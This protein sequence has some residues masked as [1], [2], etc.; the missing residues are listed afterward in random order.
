MANNMKFQI[1]K[2]SPEDLFGSNGHN[3]AANAIQETL[4]QFPEI[5]LIGLE[6]ELGAG[7]ST[8]LQLLKS[9]LDSKNFNFIEFDV[10][11]YHHSST[12]S[13][14]IK[15]L[16][17]KLKNL[18]SSHSNK[19]DE[20]KDLALGNKFTYKKEVKSNLP[21]ISF[22][23]VICLLLTARTMQPA[24]QAITD[25]ISALIS[26]EPSTENPIF[27]SKQLIDIMLGFSPLALAL[28]L[29]FFRFLG[30]KLNFN[31]LSKLPNIGS[32]LKRNSVDTISETL[33]INKEVSSVELEA[34][35]SKF[36]TIIPEN[37]VV[38]L[39]IDN[40]DRVS[41][42]KVKEI[43]SDLE[44]LT[45]ICSK[46]FRIIV[47]YSEN[48]IAS[49][50]SN[51]TK[52]KENDS[53][54][55]SKSGQEFISKR[56]PVVFRAPPI[57]SAGWREPFAKYWE[58]TLPK[59]AGMSDVSDLIDVW[60]STL[61][62]EQ[63][64]PRF[65]KKHINDIASIILSNQ[66]TNP[67][68][69]CCSAYLLACKL[70]KI[71]VNE[72]LSEP[73]PKAREHKCSPKVEATKII[74][75]KVVG[76]QE[77]P[78]EIMAIHYQTTTE[79]A[80]CELLGEP[81][82]RA[83]KNHNGEEISELAKMYG[84]TIEFNKAMLSPNTEPYDLV[85]LAHS[86]ILHHQDTNVE[87][88]IDQ[89]KAWLPEINHALKEH[90]NN[91]NLDHYNL[92]TISAFKALQDHDLPIN[93][94][95]IKQEIKLVENEIVRNNQEM[96][97]DPSQAT[98]ILYHYTQLTNSTPSFVSNPSNAYFINTLWPNRKK[99]E[100]WGI[101]HHKQNYSEI[102]ECIELIA[103]TDSYST[104]FSYFEYLAKTSVINQERLKDF[105]TETPIATMSQ[106]FSVE[107]NLSWYALPFTT[108]WYQSNQITT[109]FDQCDIKLQKDEEQ[110]TTRIWLSVLIAYYIENGTT[111][112]YIRLKSGSRIKPSD[113][114]NQKFEELDNLDEEVLFRLLS[115]T[116]SFELILDT[117]KNDTLF[118]LLKNT[119][120]RLWKEG[121]VKAL[122]I[123]R[124]YSSD[125]PVLASVLEDK[126][127]HLNKLENWLPKCTLPVSDWSEE[128]IN[129]ILITENKNFIEFVWKEISSINDIAVLTR[130]LSSEDIPESQFIINQFSGGKNKLSNSKFIAD[131]LLNI[132]NSQTL[133]E[134]NSSSVA[135]KLLNLLYSRDKQRVIRQIK[136]NLISSSI[137]R[138]LKY[139]L[140]EYFGSQVQLDS[141][142]NEDA[143]TQVISLIDGLNSP[144]V[145]SWMN[146]QLNNLKNWGPDKLME[147]KEATE[148]HS[149]DYD[150]NNIISAYDKEIIEQQ[151]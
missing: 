17:S 125:Y 148:V 95:R 86:A 123:E 90:K 134:N 10:E 83:I 36:V 133:R 91:A 130:I 150:L 25:I 14:F 46:Q 100:R 132:I 39:I 56:I 89:V 81:I 106:V 107:K 97:S 124:A 3:N 60:A 131:M 121:K 126:T 52:E 84:F 75:R 129:D 128:L 49:A 108:E 33:L 104:R 23:L 64:T 29:V 40:L 7:K 96:D 9:K 27:T 11:K 71:P 5:H 50:L 119:A 68:A 88:P 151:A 101:D 145:A 21:W 76:T 92:D 142:S 147:L 19:I 53:Q 63:I 144:K 112:E 18:Y 44:I 6:G 58:E 93:L 22:I 35:F 117:C 57:M 138:S 103:A 146:V 99:L 120:K 34:A 82:K 37:D 51:S 28:G 13:S 26:S 140:I 55:C 98:D 8:V 16:S 110:G 109:M 87:S 59:R 122:Q 74:L 42:K 94:E 73:F 102:Q 43:W 38:I 61:E 30:D 62:S 139:T 15:I 1:E 2:P 115:M 48:H 79:L 41:S 111:S 118:P 54:E 135:L 105:V 78:L 116:S 70:N 137:D 31:W 20:A 47:P 72:F 85:R 143:Q 136:T 80:Q 45:S 113:F 69:C 127:E 149:K 12:K 24:L 65:L 141:L 66:I 77:W 32:A 114:I 67:S 4:E